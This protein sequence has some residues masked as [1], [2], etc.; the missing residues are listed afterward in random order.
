[1][2]ETHRST[3]PVID[4]VVG[5][6]AKFWE[7]GRVKTRLGATIGM[8][9]SAGLHQRFVKQLLCQL[10]SPANLTAASPPERNGAGQAGWKCQWVASPPDRIDDA[11]QQ[12]SQWGCDGIE[13]VDQGQGDLGDRMLRWFRK[14][15]D[16]TTAGSAVLI[17]ADCPCLTSADLA[18]AL[19][20]LQTSD[21]VLGPA[22]DGGYYLVGLRSPWRDDFDRLFQDIT[23]S[24]PDVFE[25]T[26]QRV[27]DQGLSLSLLST[28]EDV[29]TESELTRLRQTLA[30]AENRHNADAKALLDDIE[31]IL[32][33]NH[34]P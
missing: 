12:V 5:V 9:Q 10:S 23:W 33:A 18:D 21:V 29:D 16:G 30:A 2:T 1:M 24:G 20:E 28:R 32:N 13:V 8:D 26:C 19:D 4:P 31:T 3:D 27:K 7:S 34:E 11:R 15:L 14:Q 22:A 25:V 17:G 6:M